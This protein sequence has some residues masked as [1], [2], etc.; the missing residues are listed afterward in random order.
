MIVID[1]SIKDNPCENDNS[2]LHSIKGGC[3]TGLFSLSINM[4]ML[5]QM[6]HLYVVWPVQQFHKTF[7]KMQTFSKCSI[8]KKCRKILTNLRNPMIFH[9]MWFSLLFIFFV[10]HFRVRLV[11]SPTLLK[12]PYWHEQL[13][14]RLK[15]N[16]QFSCCWLN[17][18][19]PLSWP[20]WRNECEVSP[21]PFCNMM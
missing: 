10:L 9:K 2:Y 7:H 1:Q 16:I 20:A 21:H 12:W 15:N 5:S 4:S 3:I 14:F 8:S 17:I 18:G 11:Y 6:S 13:W 19:N